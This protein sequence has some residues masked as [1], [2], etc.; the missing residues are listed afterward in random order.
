M[1]EPYKEKPISPDKGKEGGSC[2]V[3]HCQEPHSAFCYNSVMYAWYCLRCARKINDSALQSKMKPFINIP[4]DYHE[5]W[6]NAV[7][8]AEEKS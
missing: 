4:E 5:K 2:N 3:T 6:Q 7:I 8:A 1:F